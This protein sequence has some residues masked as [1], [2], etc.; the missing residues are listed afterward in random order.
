MTDQEQ[1]KAWTVERVAEVVRSL[2]EEDDLPEH[3]KSA[4][5]TG[6]D[7]VETLGLDSLGAVYLIERLEEV[8]GI[9]LPDD[10]LNFGD[11]IAVIADSINDFLD[12]G[13]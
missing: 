4:Q 10:F 11:S 6:Q 9:P 8:A 5:I 7:T 3:L 13:A 2:A 12:K 1:V